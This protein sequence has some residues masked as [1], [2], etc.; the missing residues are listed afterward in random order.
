LFV[1]PPQFRLLITPA[2]ADTVRLS[3]QPW[4]PRLSAKLAVPEPEGVPVIVYVRLP[5]PLDSVPAASV[6][7]RPVTPVELTVCPL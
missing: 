2:G 4:P 6:A 5:L 3:V 1:A 7:V